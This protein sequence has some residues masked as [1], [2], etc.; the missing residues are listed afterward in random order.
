MSLVRIGRCSVEN[1]TDLAVVGALLQAL[2]ALMDR[3]DT[4]LPR[5]REAFGCRIDADYGDQLHILGV[6]Y[7]LDHQFVSDVARSVLLRL[8]FFFLCFFP[9]FKSLFL[10]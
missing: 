9:Y 10:I 4:S 6:F 8:Y 7:H 1:D 3:S 2:D 5:H